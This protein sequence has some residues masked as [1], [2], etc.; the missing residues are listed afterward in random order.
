M[1]KS[2]MK[3][4]ARGQNGANPKRHLHS[5]I[6]HSDFVIVSL[7]EIS[8]FVIVRSRHSIAHTYLAITTEDEK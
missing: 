8:L 6:R 5:A 3:K 2:E 1:T 7:F 4:Q